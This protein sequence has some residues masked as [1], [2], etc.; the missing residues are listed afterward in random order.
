MLRVLHVSRLVGQINDQK[1]GAGVF[2]AIFE[3]ALVSDRFV[4]KRTKFN[5]NA[6]QQEIEMV[7][8][9][10]AL[11]ILC[12]AFKIGPKFETSLPFAVVCYEDAAE[13]HLEKCESFITHFEN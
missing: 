6:N 8:H 4:A 5:G 9:E 7:I 10:A 3:K 1:I 12:S 13:F 11:Y 2:G